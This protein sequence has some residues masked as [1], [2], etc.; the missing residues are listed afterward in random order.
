VGADGEFLDFFTQSTTAEQCVER[1]VAY[2]EQD[3]AD[4]KA[5]AKQ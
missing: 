4:K 3:L 1:T 5:A 2:I